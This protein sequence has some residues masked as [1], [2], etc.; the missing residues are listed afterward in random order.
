MPKTNESEIDILT[1]KN[2]TFLSSDEEKAVKNFLVE[3]ANK[4]KNLQMQVSGICGVNWEF[5]GKPRIIFNVNSSL[6]A[7]LTVLNRDKNENEHV[8]STN[9]NV[10]E[11]QDLV[12]RLTMFIMMRKLEGEAESYRCKL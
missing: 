7:T 2:K 4:I 6:D 5:H 9:V 10:A 12:Q 3:S 1:L 8:L 11:A